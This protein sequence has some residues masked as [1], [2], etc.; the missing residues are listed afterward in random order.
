MRVFF[1]MLLAV[2]VG[3]FLNAY[4]LTKWKILLLGRFYWLRSVSAS[5]VG[6]LC[7]TFISLTFDLLHVVPL[8]T[9]A[10]LIFVSYTVK[11]IFTPIAAVPAVYIVAYLKNL[12]GIDVYDVNTNFNPFT[13]K[14]VC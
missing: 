6:Q 12:E 9:L 2:V 14:I 8:H 5:A 11:L 3:S 13:A 10:E 1:G 7:F 4:A